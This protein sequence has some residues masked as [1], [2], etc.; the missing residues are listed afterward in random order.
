MG[1]KLYQLKYYTFKNVELVNRGNCLMARQR[2][3]LANWHLTLY[4]Q[5]KHLNTQLYAQGVRDV[6][7][8][9]FQ[10]DTISEE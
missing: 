1:S 9:A 10:G 3:G 6:P 5:F 8:N 4:L 7:F 2:N